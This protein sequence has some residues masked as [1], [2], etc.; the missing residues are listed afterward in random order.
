M[1]IYEYECR[2]CGATFDVMVL[3]ASDDTAPK[4]EQCGSRSVRKLV[5]RV[6]YMGGPQE[7]DLASRAEQR[8]LKSMG[9][10]VSEGMRKEIQHLSKTAASRGKRRL[11]KMMDTG[12]SDPVD[13]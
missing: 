13:Y 10:N 1:P 9:G 11:S 12:N 7:N 3:S 8:M 2:K 5:S 6:R 4:C